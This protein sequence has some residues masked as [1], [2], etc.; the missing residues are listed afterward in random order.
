MAVA[1]DRAD[2][3]ELRVALAYLIGVS[4]HSVAVRRAMN[5]ALDAIS[6]HR[7]HVQLARQA[8]DVSIG[9]DW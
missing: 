5:G 8:G 9:S 2:E 6:T 3:D 7:A 4:A 1:V